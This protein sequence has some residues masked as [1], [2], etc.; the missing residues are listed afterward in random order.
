M[1]DFVVVA[2]NDADASMVFLLANRI[3]Q[4]EGPDWMDAA[5]LPKWMD[6]R[7]ECHPPV[8]PDGIPRPKCTQWTKLDDKSFAEHPLRSLARDSSGQAQG[9]DFARGRKAALLFKQLRAQAGQPHSIDALIL[10]RDLDVK[11]L[12]AQERRRS[13]ELVRQESPDVVIILALPNPNQEAWVLNGFLPN[14]AE[15]AI[16]TKLKQELGFDPCHKAE[17]LSASEETAKR[18][19]KRVV[20]KLTENSRAR[21]EQCWTDTPLSVLRQRGQETNLAAYLKEVSDHLLPLLDPSFPNRKA[22]A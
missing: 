2:E 15:T 12:Q 14:Q 1:P 7:G 13:L 21:K 19:A 18:N 6:L 16:L 4:E 3:F 8:T 5:Y 20:T 17:E 9:F 22:E 10:V 11:P